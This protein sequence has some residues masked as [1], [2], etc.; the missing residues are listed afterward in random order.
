MR[1]TIFFEHEIRRRPTDRREVIK[2]I[3][4]IFRVNIHVN[5]IFVL[6]GLFVFK[7]IISG[8]KY[9]CEQNYSCYSRDSCSKKLLVVKNIISGLK[10]IISGQK[11]A[12]ASAASAASA[13]I[14][15]AMLMF[16]FLI[17]F[18]VS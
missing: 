13:A 10:N 16:S 1:N 18:S 6:F 7:N 17:T 11:T 5:R 12:I 3:K 2:R 14:V 4:R 15:S 8:L 9:P